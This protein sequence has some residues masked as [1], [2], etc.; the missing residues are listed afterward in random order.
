[1]IDLGTA[2]EQPTPQDL[3]ELLRDDVQELLTTNVRGE[4][5]SE[6]TAQNAQVRRNHYYY[7]GRQYLI[8]TYIGENIIDYTPAGTIRN[9]PA[10]DDTWVRP[11]QNVV[12]TMRGDGRKFVAVLGQ[13]MP[14]VKAMPDVTDDETCIR[15]SRRADGEA[16]KMFF[17]W[18]CE[19]KQRELA[20]GLWK[21]TTMF[22]FLDWATSGE[23]YGHL[24][25][26]RY[27][28]VQQ[29]IEPA[30]YQC[31]RCGNDTP[32]QQNVTGTCPT[33]GTP[34]SAANYRPGQYAMVPQVVGTD[35][36]EKGAVEF[37]L[38]DVT[39]VTTPFYVKGIADTPWLLYEYEA[40]IGV[41]MA[42]FP[43]LRETDPGLIQNGTAG[44]GVS[45][46][47]QMIRETFASPTATP[48]GTRR[49]RGLFGRLWLTPAMY[50][51]LQDEEKRRIFKE[52]FPEGARVSLVNDKVV[53]I[54]PDKLADHWIECK[55]DT[56][57]YIYCDPQCEDFVHIQ[58]LI[59]TFCNIS[60][61][62]FER[63]VPWFLVNPQALDMQQ[64]SKHA[65]H[66]AEMVPAL[67]TSAE[68]AIWKAPT[69]TMDPAVQPWLNGMVTWGRENSGILPQIFGGGESLPTARQEEMRRNQA[70]MQLGS[71][72]A[73]MR[74]FW[75][76]AF[77]LGIKLQAQYGA[78]QEQAEFNLAESEI[79]TLSSLTDG[80]FHF[81][82]AEAM[83]MTWAQW[84]DFYMFLLDKGPA[85]WDKLG[86]FD[87]ANLPHVQ[88]ILGMDGWKIPNL[89]ARDKV[90]DCISKLLKGKPTQNNGKV[91]PSLPVDV[92]EDDHLFAAQVVK[93]WAQEA[94]RAIRESNPDGYSNVIAWGMAHMELTMPDPAA[95][96]PSAPQGQ[97]EP[98]GRPREGKVGPPPTAPVQLTGEPQPGTGMAVQ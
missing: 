33:C 29:E 16:R 75:A 74:R 60:E 31:F 22:G 69:A 67:K 54:E 18:D 1:M 91:E 58:N 51:L 10:G 64:L 6:K 73:E 9:P 88:S 15:R 77:M 83:P 50:E 43:D 30:S 11:Y 40:H 49:D 71:V 28:D 81:E 17:R 70:L 82:A 84:R 36:F 32:E 34:F 95:A 55:P 90:F 65:M 8:P 21:T 66:P 27:E 19:R 62:T 61:Q 45:N 42:A 59:N 86:M 96:P 39:M 14:S 5:Q 92:W 76:A 68:N 20:L 48:I 24:E 38:A 2:P 52:Q 13:R 93:E 89:G 98:T 79:A 63:G 72:W 44:D 87:P 94:G 12:N 3:L 23:K 7:Q 78:A 26:P 4:V 80:G 37:S 35:K 25:I 97:Q 47:S 53:K 85:L 57:E 41:L 46:Q 56:S